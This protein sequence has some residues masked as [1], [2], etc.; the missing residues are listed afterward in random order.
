MLWVFG[1]EDFLVTTSILLLQGP[2]VSVQSLFPYA[3]CP[4][5]GC[6]NG[7]DVRGQQAWTEKGLPQR[8]AKGEKTEWPCKP[9]LLETSKTLSLSF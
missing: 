6:S 3:L 8:A 7:C 1:N 2:W 4:L 5:S 9:T